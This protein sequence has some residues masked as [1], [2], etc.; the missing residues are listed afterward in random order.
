MHQIDIPEFN[1]A[2]QA[3]IEE[4][5]E[6]GIK[7]RAKWSPEIYSRQDPGNGHRNQGRT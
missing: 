4:L 6:E 3:L 1:E 5:E 2:R 7:S